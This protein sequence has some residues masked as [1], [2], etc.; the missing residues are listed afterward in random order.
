[1][2]AGFLLQPPDHLCGVIGDL[3]QGLL[4]EDLR[5]RAGHF[6]RLGIVGPVRGHRGI[7]RV[8]EQVG[9]AIPAARQQPEPV[10]EYDRRPP[11][12]VR[13]LDL[14]RFPLSDGSWSW[15]A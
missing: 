4:G 8:L 11:A 15:V 6:N 9:P 1:M 12:R 5:L 3:L 13:L 7:A 14:S 10:D 2:T